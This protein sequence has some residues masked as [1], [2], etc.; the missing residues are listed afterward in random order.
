MRNKKCNKN[1]KYLFIFRGKSVPFN[2]HR[3][4]FRPNENKKKKKKEKRLQKKKETKITKYNL[5]T[6]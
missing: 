3:F 5:L 2:F 1:K 6:K 4:D